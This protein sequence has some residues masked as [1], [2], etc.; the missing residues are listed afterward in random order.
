MGTGGSQVGKEPERLTA[1]GLILREQ[2]GNLV[3]YRANPDAA[4]HHELVGLV[5]K[6]FAMAE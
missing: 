1:A 3:F 2:R 5:A 4:V 6:S